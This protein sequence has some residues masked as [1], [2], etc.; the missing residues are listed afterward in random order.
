[1]GTEGMKVAQ[2][3]GL[4]VLEVGDF[5]FGKPSRVTAAASLGEVG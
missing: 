4:S 1:M 2:V 5:A 3:N